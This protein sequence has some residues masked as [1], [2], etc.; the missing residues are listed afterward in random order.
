MFCH[1]M[2]CHDC[3]PLQSTIPHLLSA[4]AWLSKAEG[5][6]TAGA[7]ASVHLAVYPPQP[8]A[9]ELAGC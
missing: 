8:V 4:L 5:W 7:E 2:I 1:G 9:A 3:A 6:M